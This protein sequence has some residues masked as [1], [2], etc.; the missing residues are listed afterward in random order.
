MG[1]VGEVT[2]TSLG[3]GKDKSSWLYAVIMSEIDS[4][5]AVLLNPDQKRRLQEEIR[6][7]P[8]QGKFLFRTSLTQR[9]PLWYCEGCGHMTSPT[10]HRWECAYHDVIPVLIFGPQAVQDIEEAQARGEKEWHGRSITT[11]LGVVRWKEDGP[12]YMEVVVD[13]QRTMRMVSHYEEIEDACLEE[14]LVTMRKVPVLL[15]D[16]VLRWDVEGVPRITVVP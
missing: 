3:E 4:G 6:E 12:E 2:W 8:M 11:L 1:T 9:Q 5:A 15:I 10:D 13:G 7:M 16:E 14:N